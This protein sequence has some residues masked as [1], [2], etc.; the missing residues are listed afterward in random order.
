[1]RKYKITSQVDSIV[2][3]IVLVAFIASKHLISIKDEGK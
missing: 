3:G 2:T 1:M